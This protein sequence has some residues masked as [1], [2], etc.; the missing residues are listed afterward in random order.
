[1]SEE[2]EAVDGTAE[3]EPSPELQPVVDALLPA[4]I[5]P[6]DQHEV[7]VRMDEADVQMLLTWA[8]GAALRKW[9][10]DLPG[11]KGTGLTVHAVQDVVQR[12]NWS[13]KAKIG[14]LP[15][16][17]TVETIV[18]DEGEGGETYWVATIF[19]RDEL[20]GSSLPGS[21][22]EPQRM[23][24]KSGKRVFDRFARWKAIQKAT[25]NALS[26]FI[27]EEI[28]QTVIAMFLRD[29]SRV[30]RIRTE[31][32]AKV[33]ELPAPLTDD[34][35]KGLISECEAVYDEI[36][37]LGGGQGKVLLTPGTYNAWLL[38][39]QHDHGAL[40]RM[41]EYLVQRRGEIAAQFEE[42]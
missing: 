3:E 32:E 12:M 42:A 27:P 5:D 39:S 1:M 36:K 7:M 33:A 29:S 8:Q 35:A 34:E 15:E 21:S 17:L 20:T 37:G 30:Q 31:A 28:E 6:S 16:T 10:Y 18:A 41:L 23:K 11:N 19:A 26:G 13:G 9:V 40:R 22:M 24:L 4:V 14:V 2:P 38:Q 25:R